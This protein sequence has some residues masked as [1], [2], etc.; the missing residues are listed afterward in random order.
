MKTRSFTD[1]EFINAVAVSK[2]VRQVLIL[3]NLKQAGGNYQTVRK[4]VKELNVDISHFTGQLW[5][6]GKTLHPKRAIEDYISNKHPISSHHLR[7]RL[8][9]EGFFDHVCSRCGMNTWM[10]MPIPIELHHLDGNHQNNHLQ[11]IS[12]L[13]PNCHAQTPYYRGKNIGAYPNP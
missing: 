11:N 12:L 9:K 4:L 1:T 2:S 10:G 5:S 7:K 8:I 6:K 13:C 3:L